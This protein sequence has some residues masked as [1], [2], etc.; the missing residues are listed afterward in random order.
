MVSENS[1]VKLAIMKANLAEQEE[2]KKNFKRAFDL[3]KEAVEILMPIAEGIL[4][5]NT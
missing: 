2:A 1:H 3:Y 5:V 4:C